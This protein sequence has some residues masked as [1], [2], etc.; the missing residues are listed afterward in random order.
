MWVVRLEIELE[1]KSHLRRL[2]RAQLSKGV[3]RYDGLDQQEV[4]TKWTCSL[5]GTGQ[6]PVIIGQARIC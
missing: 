3:F 4:K 5:G 2:S 6:V 1:A